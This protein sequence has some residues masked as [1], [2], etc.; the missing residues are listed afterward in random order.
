MLYQRIDTESA[1]NERRDSCALSDSE[2]RPA[3]K[4]EILSKQNPTSDF[5]VIEELGICRGQVRVDVAVVNGALH[6]FEIKSDRD[7]LRRLPK[8]VDFYSKVLDMA[9][10]V[11]GERHL[12]HALGEVPEWWGVIVT[13]TAEHETHF[14]N[15]RPPLI[16]KN[17]MPRSLVELLW[18]EEALLLL[19]QRNATRGVRGK[20]REVAWDRVCEVYKIEE[21]ADAVRG[22]L[23]ARVA[24]RYHPLRLRCD[25][26]CPTCARPLE[27]Q[28]CQRP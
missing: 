27:N 20:P 14:L 16:N 23:K 19:E 13:K 24:T 28:A 25:E 12:S 7:S 26:L 21:I 15:Y 9:T 4:K 11:V 18:H 10:L 5:V 8:Q 2:I 17:V 1:T 22:Q 6:G 3:L